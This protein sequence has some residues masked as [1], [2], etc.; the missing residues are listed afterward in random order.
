MWETIEVMQDVDVAIY[1]DGNL[2]SEIRISGHPEI[3]ADRF[4]EF[5]EDF[6]KLI[7]KYQVRHE[8]TTN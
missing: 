8:L 5:A 3:I 7:E 4:N 1:R 2:Y 6:K